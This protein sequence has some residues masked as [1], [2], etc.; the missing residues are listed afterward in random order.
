MAFGP[1]SV[2]PC[3]ARCRR[4]T[5]PAML[6]GSSMVTGAIGSEDLALRTASRRASS[7]ERPYRVA[8]TPDVTAAPPARGCLGSVS[9]NRYIRS[10]GPWVV[11]VF[12]LNVAFKFG[13][14][15]VAWPEEEDESP[16][17]LLQQRA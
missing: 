5:T 16:T 2:K 7:A 9:R 3:V 15:L 12:G 17:V 14:N 1:S 13:D 8:T 10:V 6:L 11:E 4:A